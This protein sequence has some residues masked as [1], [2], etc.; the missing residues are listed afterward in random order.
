MCLIMSAIRR[1]CNDDL[2]P[3]SVNK[4]KNDEPL[5]TNKQKK[6]S[7]CKVQIFGLFNLSSKDFE[8]GSAPTAAVTPESHL[9]ADKAETSAAAARA[10]SLAAFVTNGRAWL[11]L[12]EKESRQG[13]QA[14]GQ[15][16]QASNNKTELQCP[17]IYLPAAAGSLSIIRHRENQP[18]HTPPDSARFLPSLRPTQDLSWSSSAAEFASSESSHCW[19]SSSAARSSTRGCRPISKS[20]RQPL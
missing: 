9:M 10:S 4:M 2:P 19:V 16:L 13:W 3:Q 1:M 8:I 6:P 11:H 5:K 14:G 17:V 7:K 20:T 18:K 15:W 12:A